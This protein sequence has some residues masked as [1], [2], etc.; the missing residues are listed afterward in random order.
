MGRHGQPGGGIPNIPRGVLQARLL[1]GPPTGLLGRQ[2]LEL[3]VVRV[4]VR[5]LGAHGRGRRVGEGALLAGAH[6]VAVA[7]ARGGSPDPRA[8]DDRVHAGSAAATTVAAAPPS[9]CASTRSQPRPSRGPVAAQIGRVRVD[10]VVQGAR[11]ESV[12]AQIDGVRVPAGVGEGDSETPHQR[13]RSS[14][15]RARAARDARSTG[16][17]HDSR[18]SVSGAG[19]GAGM[20]TAY[21]RPEAPRAGP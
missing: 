3:D 18:G 10:R 5:V 13:A 14:R 19:A 16:S 1:H 6:D 7:A 20:A 17:P 2:R 9:E 15:V 4:P 8:R 21:E 12:P 11:R